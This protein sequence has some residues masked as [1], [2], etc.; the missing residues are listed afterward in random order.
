M[1]YIILMHISGFIYL[2]I[3]AN[4]LSLALYFIFILDYR[5]VLDKK[6]T[7]AFS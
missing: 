6:Q 1:L 2:F 4:D 3:F 5:N 7:Q